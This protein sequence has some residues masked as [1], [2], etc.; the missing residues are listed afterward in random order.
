M[1][2]NH[3]P[4]RVFNHIFFSKSWIKCDFSSPKLFLS[5]NALHLDVHVTDQARLACP[6]P[7]CYA[8]ARERGS[9]WHSSWGKIYSHTQFEWMD[10]WFFFGGGPE[11]LLIVMICYDSHDSWNSCEAPW[12]YETCT[13]IIISSSCIV[14]SF[15]P[16]L[17]CK[18]LLGVH[19]MVE[20]VIGVR[21]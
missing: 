3:Q 4:D 11:V 7:L 9:N 17:G 10:G 12:M 21:T 19:N 6:W 2:W 14:V 20:R 8:M 13:Y 16:F 5:W 18:L 1:G 15:L